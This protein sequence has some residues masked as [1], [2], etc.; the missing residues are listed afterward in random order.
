MLADLFHAP[1]NGLENS[2]GTATIGSSE[3]ILLAGLAMVSNSIIYMATVIP[4]SKII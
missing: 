2:C 1:G 3:A 4:S